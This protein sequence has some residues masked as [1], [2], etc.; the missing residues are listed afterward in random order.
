M[1]LRI[2]V[3]DAPW[4]RSARLNCFLLFVFDVWLS[5]IEQDE[6]EQDE[7]EQDSSLHR[8]VNYSFTKPNMGAPGHW[9][10]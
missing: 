6:I 9:Q 2:H 3:A 7:I 8:M 5:E 10:L 4:L 1:E